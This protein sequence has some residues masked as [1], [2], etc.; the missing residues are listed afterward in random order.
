LQRYAAISGWEN[1]NQNG[2]I[3]ANYAWT[4]EVEKIC[5]IVNHTLT[6]QPRC[7]YGFPGRYYACHAEKQLIAYYLYEYTLDKSQVGIETPHS[8]PYGKITPAAPR[9]AL[10]VVSR[11]VCD[12]CK[13]FIEKVKKHFKIPDHFHV[14]SRTCPED[15]FDTEMTTKLLESCNEW[16]SY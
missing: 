12:D 14:E 15:I 11:E 5:Q 10:I 9:G 1:G 13:L 3:I 4:L 16:R 8:Y 7:D 6:S 2:N